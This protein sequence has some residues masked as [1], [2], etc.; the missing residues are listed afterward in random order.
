MSAVY[1]IHHTDHTDMFSQGYVGVSNN[2]RNRWN[3]HRTTTQNNHLK[4]AINKYG[5]E[6]LVK[7]VIVVA[8]K[9][10][11]LDIEFKLRPTE[12]I[13]WNIVAGGGN[14]PSALGRKVTNS[15]ETRKKMSIAKLGTV[16]NMLG[17]NHTAETKAKMS[18][19]KI[20]KS[21]ITEQGRKALSL[22]HKGRK[23]AKVKCTH[24]DK[25]G[26][27]IPMKRWHMDNCKLKDSK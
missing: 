25:M 22:L 6:N 5:W 1:W 19:S 24:C 4:N 11:C 15:A 26:G 13:G 10:Y 9:N 12:K 20:G 14:P 27:I 23:Y 7:K 8:D 18:A 21:T 16:G 2:T 3:D 17:H